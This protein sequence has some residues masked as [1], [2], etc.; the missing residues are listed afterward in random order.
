MVAL[1]FQSRAQRGKSEIAI[2]Y[3]YWS[4]FSFTNHAIN[5]ADYNTT[6]GSPVLTYRYYVSRQ[7]T[8]GCSF[9]YENISTWG[10]FATIAPEVTVAYLDTRKTAVRIRLYG[11]VSYGVTLFGDNV[12]GYG[13]ADQ[14]GAKPWGFQ[15]S[16]FGIRVG[17]QFAAFAEIGY[18]YKGL[19]HGGLDIRVPRILKCNRPQPDEVEETTKDKES[20]D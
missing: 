2:G 12:I 1:G 14:T 13:E 19:I 5:G 4:S 9:G 3:G 8:I 16:P 6:S 20:E 7:V 10:S 11:L 15:G 17:R 18:G